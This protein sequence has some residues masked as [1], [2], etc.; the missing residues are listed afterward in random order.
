MLTIHRRR[1]VARRRSCSRGTCGAAVVAQPEDRRRL[2]DGL[3]ARLRPEPDRAAERLRE[4]RGDEEP[5]PARAGLAAPQ[6]RDA[7]PLSAGLDVQDDHR[8][9]RARRRRLHARPRPSTTPATAPSTASRCTTPLDQSG[10]EAFGDVNLVEA[11]QHSINAVFCNIGQQARR[12]R[13]SSTRRRSS[14]STR[15]RRSRRRRTSA[16][17][18]ASTHNGEA[19]RP[20]DAGQ[21]SQ[22]DPGRLAFG[23]DKMLATPLQMALVAAAVANNGVEMTPTLIQKIVSPGG[24]AIS[25]LAAA[26]PGAARSSRRPPRE[27]NE[28]DGRGRPG[29]HRHAGADPGR[30]R[31]RQDRHRRDRLVQHRLRRLVHLL[32]PGR[33]TRSSPARSSSRTST[34]GFGGAVAAPIAKQLMQ[35]ILPVAS[36]TNRRAWPLT[37]ND[38]LIGTLFD[39]RYLIVRKLGS[40]GMADVYLAEDQELG[41]KVALK[42]LERAPRARRA[43]RRALQARG[44]ERRRPQPSEHR[45]GST[46]AARPRAPTTSRWSTSTARR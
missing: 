1:A 21:Y 12:R 15:C 8:R 19:L 13:G 23:Q 46:T 14:A 16:R 34:N 20:E 2:R 22:V 43:V 38:S 25:K 4:G 40:G 28:H 41:R 7:G 35:A 32:R 30:R 3:V 18:R 27:L 42:M 33:T 31:R 6:P 37:S 9:G 39:G 45:L 26:R 10:P 36:N 11:Y 24:S 17:R 5:V 29:R 44:A